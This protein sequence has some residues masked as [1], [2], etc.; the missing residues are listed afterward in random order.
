MVN[1]ARI[2]PGARLYKESW[3]GKPIIIEVIELVDHINF[4]F[5]INSES[6]LY[7]VVEHPYEAWIGSR[8]YCTKW[9]AAMSYKKIRQYDREV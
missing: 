5:Q 3:N 8:R 4:E 2:I 6:I 1:P 7:E 9:T